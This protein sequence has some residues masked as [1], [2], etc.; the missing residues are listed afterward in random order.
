MTQREFWFA[1]GVPLIVVATFIWWNTV[2]KTF[3]EEI[4]YL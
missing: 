2:S 3:G 4:A 1:I